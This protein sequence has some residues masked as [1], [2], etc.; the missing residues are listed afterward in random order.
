M[1][2]ISR[3]II[4]NLEELENFAKNIAN[5][6]YGGMFI[7]LIGD[8]GAGK[9]Q[10]TKFFVKNLGGN[11]DDVVSPTFTILNEY[12]TEKFKV[13]HFDL[14][15]L[16]SIDELEEIGYKDFF[17][18]KNGITVVEWIDRIPEC[19]PDKYHLIKFNFVD[20]NPEWR[21]IELREV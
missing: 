5:K 17:F 6:S 12:D 16:N 13:Y 11:I 19:V 14:Y 15:R 2:K 7:G 9:T 20:N 8:L 4:K 18:D 1:E 21:E 3:L 10:F